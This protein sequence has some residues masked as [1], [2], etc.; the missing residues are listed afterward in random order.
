[1]A[2]RSPLIVKSVSSSVVPMIEVQLNLRQCQPPPVLGLGLSPPVLQELSGSRTAGHHRNQIGTGDLHLIK[3]IKHLL[4]ACCVLAGEP[5]SVGPRTRV[6]ASLRVVKFIPVN[7]LLLTSPAIQT[8]AKHPP[9]P[10]PTNSHRPAGQ[11]PATSCTSRAVTP[12]RAAAGSPIIRNLL[13]PATAVQC[14]E[15]AA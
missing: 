8:P 4:A 13:H 7:S 15:G 6:R 3:L 11:I 12:A 9:A 10:P 1:M 5:S 2:A 14:R